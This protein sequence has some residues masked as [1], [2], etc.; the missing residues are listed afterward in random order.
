MPQQRAAPPGPDLATRRRAPIG[1][2]E[3][4]VIVE[5]CGDLATFQSIAVDA[6]DDWIADC[7][8]GRRRSEHVDDA[9]TRQ[10]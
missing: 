8:L 1:P 6:H 3:L 5:L 10:I 4:L 2:E 7:L 9:Q